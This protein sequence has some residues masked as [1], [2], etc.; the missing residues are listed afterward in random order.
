[1][2]D[3]C[4]PWP[5]TFEKTEQAVNRT[6][7]WAKLFFEKAREQAIF[8]R[9]HLVFGIVQ[10]STYT[11]LRKRCAEELAEINFSGFAIGG[12]SVGEPEPEMLMQVAATTPFLPLEKPRYVMGVGTP[13]QLLKMIALGADMFDCV[14]PTRLARHGIAFTPQGPINI[15]NE[16]FKRDERPLVEDPRDPCH[17]FSRAYLRHLVIA[18]E[19]LA[20]TLLSLHNVY[21]FLTLMNEARQ[22]I[23]AG[24]FHK[25][26]LDW[27]AAYQENKVKTGVIKTSG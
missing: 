13:P 25:W 11:A 26:H 17:H 5:C 9:G 10:G 21:F 18:K 22:H 2:L 6:V 14:M 15:R 24:D 20:C 27:I 4:P 1:V 3:E 23:Q 12:V 19:L 16:R 7:K 8:D